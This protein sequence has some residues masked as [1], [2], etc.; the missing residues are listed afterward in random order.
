MKM[1]LLL[2]RLETS[3]PDQH[4]RV[5]SVRNKLV[6]EALPYQGRFR[7]LRVEHEDP[8]SFLWD[9]QNT[10]GASTSAP[11]VLPHSRK[12]YSFLKPNMVHEDCNK[13]ELTKFITDGRTWLN[14]TITEEDKKEVEMVYAALR[15]TYIITHSHLHNYIIHK[16]IFRLHPHTPYAH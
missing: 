5:E 3:D 12:E 16:P 15:L 6:C 9:T 10:A 11:A 8:L 13:R 4:T 1:E 7:K 2:L 14:K